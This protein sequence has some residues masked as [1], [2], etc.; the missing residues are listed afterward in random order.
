MGVPLEGKIA[1]ARYGYIFRGTK[2]MIAELFGMKGMIIY[3]DPADDGY[4][5]GTVFPEGPWR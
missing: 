1:I 4:G 3:S 5:Q 2:V